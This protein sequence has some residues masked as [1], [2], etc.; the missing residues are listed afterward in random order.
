MKLTSQILSG[1]L[2]D[3]DVLAGEH[4]AQVDFAPPDADSA[5]LRDGDGAVVEGVFDLAQAGIGPRRRAVELS[6][7]LHVQRLMR[8]IMV[9][10]L[11]EVIELRLLLA[12]G[13]P[14]SV[15]IEWLLPARSSAPQ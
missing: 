2:F 9:E 15:R 4:P 13:T 11:N 14:L 5:A 12:N 10:A 8:P 1:D 3:A 6:R 7:V